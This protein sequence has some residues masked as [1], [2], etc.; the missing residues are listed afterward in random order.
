MRD[1]TYA[2]ELA[3]AEVN[4]CRIER[5]HVKGEGQDEIRFSWWPDGKMANRPL[6]LPEGLLLDLFRKAIEAGVFSDEFLRNLHSVL[7]DTR[8]AA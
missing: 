4:D 3:T 5:L 1:T 6:D 8:K 7:Y 2:T